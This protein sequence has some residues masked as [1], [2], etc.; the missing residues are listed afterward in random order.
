MLIAS[1]AVIPGKPEIHGSTCINLDAYPLLGGK[2]DT[3]TDSRMLEIH[4]PYLP[5]AWGLI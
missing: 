4:D 1:G 3:F 2:S 5:L